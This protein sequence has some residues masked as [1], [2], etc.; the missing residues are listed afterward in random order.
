MHTHKHMVWRF[1]LVHG[2][3]Q[4]QSCVKAPIVMMVVHNKDSNMVS[5][6]AAFVF[7]Q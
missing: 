5:L 6:G 7:M 3:P 4:R 2:P 1:H